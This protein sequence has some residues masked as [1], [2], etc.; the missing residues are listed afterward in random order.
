MQRIWWSAMLRSGDH[1]QAVRLLRCG[2]KGQGHLVVELL[3]HY[4]QA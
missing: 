2:E 3:K 1:S 4:S